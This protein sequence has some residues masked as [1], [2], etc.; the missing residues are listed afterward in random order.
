[1]DVRAEIARLAAILSLWLAGLAIGLIGTDVRA[2]DRLAAPPAADERGVV[3]LQSATIESANG[4]L[5][6]RTTAFPAQHIREHR[7]LDDFRLDADITLDAAPGDELWSLYVAALNHGGRVFVNGTEVGRVPTSDATSTVWHTRPFIFAF[8]GALL[9]NGAN[10]IEIRWT[11]R[12]N[13]VLV[14]RMF[15]GPLQTLEPEYKR[16]L[17]WQNTMA[18]TALVHSLVIALTLLGI[19]TLRRHQSGYLTLGLGGLGFSVIMLTYMLPPMAWWVYPYWRAV[20]IGSIGLF[21]AGAWMF[22][23]NEVRPSDRWFRRFC[24][25]WS[26]SGP[27]IYLV[28]F[29][30]TDITF[31]KAF[32]TVWGITSGLIGLYPVGLLVLSCLRRF[33]ARKLIFVTATSCAIIMGVADIL[34]QSTA[35]GM[36][37]GLGYSLQMVAPLWFTALTLVLVLDF[38]SSL[39]DEEQQRREMA[40]RLEEQRTRLEDLYAIRQH[41]QTQQATQLER[42]RIMQDMHDGLGSQLISSL[43]V[44]ESGAC[45]DRQMASL[46]RECIDDLRLAIDALSQGED[47]FL[48]ALGNLRFRMVPRMRSA[49]IELDWRIDGHDRLDRLPLPCAIP[50]LRILQETFSNVLKHAHA[51]HVDVDVRVDELGLT[52][53]VRDDGRGFVAGAGRPGKGL[54]GM[55]RRARSIGAALRIDSRTEGA[56]APA[57]T[58]GTTVRLTLAFPALGSAPVGSTEIAPEGA[59]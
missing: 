10:R 41:A 50:V 34:L 19:Y 12:E 2:T 48:I 49:G 38:S 55:E 15:V 42:Q 43:A 40:V 46:L 18:Q 22:L 37:G 9:R 11:G 52:I 26:L 29:W 54:G 57:A 7:V 13:L 20:H 25:A 47:S 30:A 45:D 24:L 32:E 31:F 6:R 8:P 51:R 33:T 39:R 35:K 59:A 5:P 56:D 3:P 44:I 36:F 17:F 23:I 1:M 4:S 58:T 28:H 53:E 14:S 21:T 16:R 27:I